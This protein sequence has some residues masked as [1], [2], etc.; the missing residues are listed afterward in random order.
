MPRSAMPPKQIPYYK[1]LRASPP[2]PCQAVSD[3]RCDSIAI[4]FIGPLPKDNGYDCILTITDR[5]GSDICI[6]PTKCTLTAQGLAELFF[7][8]WYCKN[9]LPIEIISD[10]ESATNSSSRTSGRPYM[11]LQISNYNCR[12][13]K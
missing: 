9:G 8:H 10:R 2:A 5:L 11:S 3:R 7:K 1:A 4:D 12:Q 6:I 13:A